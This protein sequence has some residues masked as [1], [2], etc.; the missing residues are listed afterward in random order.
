MAGILTVSDLKYTYSD[1]TA[2]LDGVSF[3]VAAGEK[4]AVMGSNGSGKSTLFLCLNGV[5]RAGGGTVSVGGQT[6][7]YDKKSLSENRKNVGIVFQDPETQLF[8]INVYE[9]VAFGP[10][11]LGIKN[12][13][14]DEIV[15]E[16]MSL[17]DVKEFSDKPPHFL[18]YGQKKR[19]TIASVLSMSPKI[20]IFDEPMAALDPVHSAQTESLM[21]VLNE[22]G[23]TIVMSTHDVDMAY[24]WA[25]RIA[26]L[27]SGKVQRFGTPDEVF[28]NEED[29][30][31]WNLQTPQVLRIYRKLV[32][33]GILKSRKELPRDADSLAECIDSLL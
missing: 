14:L 32:S 9:E 27:K 2:A 15:N 1:G 18:S 13:Q 12:P 22:R 16:S 33:S 29:L 31:A 21:N 3:D 28:E 25:D 6:L 4:I 11:N 30:K 19:V 20:I 24:R 23:I 5:L 7:S 10:H 26:V 8:C 17:V